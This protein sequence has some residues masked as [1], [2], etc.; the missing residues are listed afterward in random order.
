[1][2]EITSAQKNPKN[3]QYN[4][5]SS[6]KGEVVT[7]GGDE[8]KDVEILRTSEGE[9]LIDE[10]LTG[11]PVTERA[12]IKATITKTISIRVA[13]PK[14]IPV[15]W[16]IAKCFLLKM[17]LLRFLQLKL[18]LLRLLL[19]GVLYWG[20]P[21]W[22]DQHWRCHCHNISFGNR[23]SY[24]VSNHLDF[25]ETL[26]LIAPRIRSSQEE[27]AIPPVS[28]PMMLN[29]IYHNIVQHKTSSAANLSVTIGTKSTSS[30]MPV[31]NRVNL[32]PSLPLSQSQFPLSLYHILPLI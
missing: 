16:S 30:T 14:I 11:E 21:R 29:I 1:M 13:S 15:T 18:L 20:C 31:Q 7:Q 27:V 25:T 3:Q 2:R 32:G 22:D 6:R 5:G 10:P 8:I 12:P 26:R 19:L 24:T 23:F 4:F 9:K 17:L 28:D